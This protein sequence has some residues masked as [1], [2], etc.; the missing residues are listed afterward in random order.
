[1]VQQIAVNTEAELNLDNDAGVVEC[2]ADLAYR[3]LGIVNIMYLGPPE[4]DSAEWILIDAGVIGTTRAIIRGA[5]NRFGR[6]SRPRAIVLTHGH[7]DHVGTLSELA[8]EWNVPIYA[9]PLEMPYLDGSESYPAP[10]PTVGGGIM[11]AMSRFFPRGPIDVSQWLMPLPS[12]GHVPGAPSWRWIHT[13]GHTPGH[14]SLWRASD[15]T[16]IAGDAFIT[17][18]QESAYAVLTQ[19]PELHGPPMYYTPDWE[20]AHASVVRLADLEPELVISGHG[21][22]LHGEAMRTSL[23]Q[24]AR[25][26][27]QVAVPQEGKYVNRPGLPK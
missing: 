16:L 12:D 1:V 26:F 2:K 15:R 4:P 14:I 13:P 20:S 3:L 24:L 9:H 27:V 19:R 5:E 7:F 22:P 25:E 17:T 21:P 18:A 6:G 11:S 10:D 8:Q 23:T